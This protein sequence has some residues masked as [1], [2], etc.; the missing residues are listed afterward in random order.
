MS[1]KAGTKLEQGAIIGS[2][3]DDSKFTIT[4]KLSPGE[5]SRL[6]D[7]Y[8]AMI[9]FPGVFDYGEAIKGTITNINPN[10][11]PEK[12]KDLNANTG[13]KIDDDT[14]E[15]VY[16]VDIEADNPGLVQTGM[17]AE[18]TFY[19][20]DVYKSLYAAEN[21][22]S[23]KGLVTCRY[24]SAVSGYATQEEVLSQ[25]E[26]V[27]TKIVADNMAL[28]KKGDVILTMAGQDV[29]EVIVTKLDSIRSKQSQLADLQAQQQSLTIRATSDGVL[30]EFNKQ[31]GAS[32]SPG[33][34]L[35]SIFSSQ[36]MQLYAQVDDI[37]VVSI[38]S[39]DK[40]KITM[41]ALPGQTFDG[42]VSYVSA[43]GNNNNGTI[44]YDVYIDVKGNSQVKSGMQAK[45][46]VGAD[47]AKGVLLVPL[48]AIFNEDGKN[49]VET[50]D[51]NNVV[52]E[53]NVEVGLMNNSEAEITSGL[54]EGDKVITG[55]T[56][57][58]L[59]SKEEDTN[60]SIL[61]N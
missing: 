53:V 42:T 33:E 61:G 25:V 20:P 27:A 30:S 4:A 9:R 54:K 21:A 36:N 57:D 43:A 24:N 40:C 52:H 23:T 32:C 22:Q 29:T 5:F 55:S 7:S 37:D 16:W 41:D 48:E 31:A 2:I 8:C 14:Y 26:G 58:V 18:V 1:T 39:G 3:V 45:A 56:E 38:Q 47:S 35:G 28:V 12:S 10:P 44:L 11:I 15:Y 49:K 13:I 6:K 50:L 46:K 19:D 60:K 51:A 17:I 34:W 59:S